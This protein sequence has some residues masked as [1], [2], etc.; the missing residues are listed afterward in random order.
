MSLTKVSFSMIDSAPI[1]IRDYGAVGDGITDDTTAIQA[2][3]NAAIGGSL[4]VPPCSN[5]Y[6]VT[7]QITGVSNITIIG[8]GLAGTIRNTTSGTYVYMS[9]SL[10]RGA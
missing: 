10:V 3:M 5:Y 7:S 6:K 9:G 8:S 1:S 4:Y 2:A